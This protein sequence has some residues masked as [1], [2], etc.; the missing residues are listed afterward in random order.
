MHNERTK[1]QIA[2]LKLRVQVEVAQ[3]EALDKAVLQHQLK[4]VWRVLEGD[5]TP[6]EKLDRILGI[7]RYGKGISNGCKEEE[8]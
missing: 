6:S 7:V 8:L 2:S 3:A 5:T 1:N 4:E